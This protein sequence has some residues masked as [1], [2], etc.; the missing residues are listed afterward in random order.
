MAGN[1][2]ILAVT[3]HFTRNA[4]SRGVTRIYVTGTEG[5]NSI[6]NAGGRM[7]LNTSDFITGEFHSV[8]GRVSACVH[9]CC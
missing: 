8:C 5:K 6:T 9:A 4:V 2:F 1:A 7:A 3:V